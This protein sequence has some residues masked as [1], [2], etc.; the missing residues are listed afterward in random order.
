MKCLGAVYS[1]ACV[2]MRVCAY[3]WLVRLCPPA[4]FNLCR[5][6]PQEAF[7]S[8][9]RRIIGLT[10]HRLCPAIVNKFYMKIRGWLAQRVTPPP[11]GAQPQRPSCTIM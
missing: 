3:V 7:G 1:C 11:P 9:D 5:R 8:V 2:C 10:N 6:I 4:G